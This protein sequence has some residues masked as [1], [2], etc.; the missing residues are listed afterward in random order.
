MLAPQNLHSEFSAL[1]SSS[2]TTVLV[3][4]D[5]KMIRRFLEIAL[6][7]ANFDVVS[8]SDGLEA[9]RIS[10]S[11]QIHSVITDALMPNLNGYELCR[12]LRRHPR[13]KNVPVIFLSGSTPSK[14][15]LGEEIFINAH[16]I[17]PVSAE[18][19]IACLNAVL[20]PQPT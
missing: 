19:L 16:L 12:F 3:V 20:A 5:D 1:A 8:A 4:E 9:M 14:E 18:E 11:T 10:L 2:A 15:E 17:K 13:L 7:R 6:R